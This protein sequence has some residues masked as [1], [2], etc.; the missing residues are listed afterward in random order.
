MKPGDLV[1]I[2]PDETDKSDRYDG[3]I[4]LILS[5][6]GHQMDEPL[7][8]LLVNGNAEWIMLESNLEVINEAR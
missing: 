6:S 3:L 5:E 1:R 2:I 8:N 4:G 7:F